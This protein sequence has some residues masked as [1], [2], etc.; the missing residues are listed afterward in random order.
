MGGDLTAELEKTQVSAASPS[1]RREAG[2]D[3]GAREVAGFQRGVALAQEAFVK[4]AGFVAQRGVV[5]L[6]VEEEGE[7]ILRAGVG[8]D[9]FVVTPEGGEG[10]Q[11]QRWAAIPYPLCVIAAPAL[12]FVLPRETLRSEWNARLFFAALLSL[13]GF[14]FLCATTYFVIHPRI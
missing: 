13:A 12:A 5:R 1:Q 9:A 14:T 10:W 6:G 2:L 11:R 8:A 7:G 4:G 3:F